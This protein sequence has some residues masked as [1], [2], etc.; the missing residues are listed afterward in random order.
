M[1]V[2]VVYAPVASF[3]Q[4][5]AYAFYKEIALCRACLVGKWLQ[6][7][8]SLMPVALLFMAEGWGMVDVVDEKMSASYSW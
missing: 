6:G 3:A 1:V 4:V 7:S 2:P 5:G 8:A